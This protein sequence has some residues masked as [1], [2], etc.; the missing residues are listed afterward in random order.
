MRIPP[1]A[2]ATLTARL[3]AV[4]NFAG[5]GAVASGARERGITATRTSRRD[6]QGVNTDPYE[7]SLLRIKQRHPTYG[8]GK[9]HTTYFSGVDKSL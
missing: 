4:G 3:H 5:V 7:S 8:L 2:D 1:D 9:A 6:M